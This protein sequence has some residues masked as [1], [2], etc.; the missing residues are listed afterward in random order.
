MNKRETANL[1]PYYKKDGTFYFFLQ[2]RTDDAPV[3]P[4][5]IGLFGGGM[6]EGE[7]PEEGMRRETEEELCLKNVPGV[8]FCRF[9]NV[10]YINHVFMLEVDEHFRHAVTVLEGQ[11]G[12]FLS[13]DEVRAD[14][15]FVLHDRFEVL[16]LL[17]YLKTK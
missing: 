15:R 3:Y 14:P 12:L 17:E 1:I 2:W 7:T 5:M 11:D 13:E 9:E 10:K 8:F 6:D 16:E 4:S